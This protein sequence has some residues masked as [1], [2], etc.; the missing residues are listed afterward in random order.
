M[1]LNLCLV[2]LAF[3]L[4]A[5]ARLVQ[6]WSEDELRN[7][8]D[9]VVEAIP[10]ATKD[11]DETNS[12][13]FSGTASFQPR[14][15]GVETTFKVLDVLA[16]MPVNDHIVVH[17]YREEIEWGSPPNGPTLISFTPGSTNKWVLYLK[18]DGADRY[19]PVAGQVDPG[20]SIRPF[21]QEDA[22]RF[23]FALLAPLADADPTH[24]H[25]VSFQIPTQLKIVRT[26]DTRSVSTDTDSL[27][28]TNLMVGTNMVTGA[29]SEFYVY[30]VG[31]PR[32]ANPMGMGMNS[33]LN[34]SLGTSY[35]NRIRDGIPQ[36]DQSYVVEIAFAAFQTDVPAQHMWDPQ[37]DKYK[38]LLRW[39]SKQIVE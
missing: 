15:R 22:R 7:A 5:S 37:S 14:F 29:Q 2:L 16:G 30:P 20:L 8:S 35:W 21:N 13:G 18:K 39:T 24:C 10:I 38:I 36:P 9:L 26:A 1:K 33:G 32:A 34:F 27:E 28:S 12:L 31:A 25:L 23:G 4:S 11:L 3:N 19:A 6:P 17:H